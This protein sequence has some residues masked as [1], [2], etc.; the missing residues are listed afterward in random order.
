MF[1]LFHLRHDFPGAR[2]VVR[3]FMQM[4]FE[5]RHYLAF[6]FS[7]ESEVPSISGEP[8][9]AA[10]GERAGVPQWVEQTFVRAQFFDALFAPGKMIVFFRRRTPH[11]FTNARVAGGQCL[12]AIQRLGANLADMV[13]SHV[14]TRTATLGIIER[15]IIC[16]L[17]RKCPGRFS[18]FGGKRRE[19]VRH[20]AERTRQATRQADD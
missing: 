13:N 20:S 3:Q 12:A 5:M 7:D 9:E 11:A 14:T 6:G 2:I 16:G 15:V 18:G 4:P 19:R 8:G 10:D 17:R 1:V